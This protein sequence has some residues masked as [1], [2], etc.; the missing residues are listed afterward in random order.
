MRW[1]VSSLVLLLVAKVCHGAIPEEKA[2]HAIMGEARGESFR[3]KQAVAEALRRRNTLR[4]VFGAKVSANRLKR[5]KKATWKAA[6]KAWKGSKSTR[7]VPKA[8]HWF[9]ASDLKKVRN[10]RWFKKLVFVAKIGGHSF[11]YDP[12]RRRKS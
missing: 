5:E 7:L 10:R 6:T 11:Y 2:V 9:S 12:K 8:T 4:G 1:I 3:G